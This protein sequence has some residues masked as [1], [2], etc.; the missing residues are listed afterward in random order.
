MDHHSHA[1]TQQT[2]KQKQQER[3]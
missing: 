3:R 1:D 2:V